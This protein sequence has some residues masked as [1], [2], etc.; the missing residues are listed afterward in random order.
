MMWPGVQGGTW[1]SEQQHYIHIA[2]RVQYRLLPGPNNAAAQYLRHV[3]HD[4]CHHRSSERPA[5]GAETFH[6]TM[7]QKILLSWCSVAAAWAVPT[8]SL[9]TQQLVA[10]VCR[11][12]TFA[13]QNC[14]NSTCNLHR[15]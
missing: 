2:V 10:C 11:C 7:T 6:A 1:P 8:C 3:L 15:R 9:S 12:A 5:A 13:H 4:R 14:F